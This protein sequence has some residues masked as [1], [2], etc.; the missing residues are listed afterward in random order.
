MTEGV[1]DRFGS[2]G[3]GG[4]AALYAG[5]VVAALV[6]VRLILGAGRHLHGPHPTGT[7]AATGTALA[8]NTSA[9]VWR[10]L[11][12][13]AVIIVTARVVGALFRRIDQPQVVGEI[14]AG[15]MLGPSLLGAAWPGA[16]HFLF[17]PTVLPFI[18]V[19]SQVGLLFFMFLIGLEL[20]IRLLKGRGHAAGLV[21]HVSIILPFLLGAAV[22]LLVFP[23]LGSH[24]GRFVPFALFMGAS[25]S[26][27]AFP[28]LARIL[29]E[30][31]IYKTRLGAVTLTCAAIDDVTA[32]CLLAVVVAV[33]RANGAGGVLRTIGLSIA[34]VTVMIGGVRPFMA[35]L[36]RHHEEQG[37][38]GGTV[39]ALLFVGI[40]LS[41]VATDRIG[42]HAI[43]GAFLFG[44]IMPQRS[45]F[46]RELVGKLEDFTVLFLLPLFFA[47]T[48]LR[49]RVGLIGTDPRL[50]GFCLLILLVAVAGKL[51][52]SA[53][54]AR[55]VGLEWR[56]SLAVGT[57]MNTRGLTELI[58]L[59]IGL[60]LG[61][62]PPTLFAMLVLMAL[63][64]TFMTTPA[65]SLVY[66]GGELTPSGEEVADDGARRWRVLVPILSPLAAT[67]LVHTA[68]RLVRDDDERPQIILLRVLPLPGSAYRTGPLAQEAM[69]ERAS[70]RLRPLVQLVE[71]AG[72]EAVPLVV[73]SGSVAATVV[74][75]AEER[76][77]DVVLMSWHRSPFG[78][79]LLGGTVGDV[80]RQA[81]ADVAVLIDPAHRGLA[82]PKGAGI[83]V[84]WGGGF[85]EDVGIDLALRLARSSRASV[86]LVGAGDADSAHELA[87]RAARAYQGTGVWTAALPVEGD[88]LPAV[89]ERARSADLVVLGVGDR[90]AREQRTLGSLR[91][92][93]T[94][95][96]PTP[97]LLVRRHGQPGA[98]R[99]G[100]WFRRHREWMDDTTGELDLR[101][102]AAVEAEAEAAIVAA[103]ERSRL[104]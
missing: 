58:I 78:R 4:S 42:I 23:Q 100:R 54:A 27:T 32:W 95:R 55:F 39:L 82:L 30:R 81:Q 29:T 45:E 71:G 25:M 80:L 17:G 67:E 49:T 43:F 70:E 101:E 83:V 22:S 104:P 68:I 74:R 34:F 9:V 64:T 21:S 99:P 77:P 33:A 59:N 35:R 86:T 15:I 28:V 102:V 76:Q 90:W 63:V 41:A 52:G 92:A 26:I 88:L 50:W 73:P 66:P 61:V 2:R 20:D 57:L 103:D 48:G 44:A 53:V 12:A 85:H 56:E 24:S 62:L 8:I 69:V 38:L 13:S 72:Y 87:E 16:T 10:L 11:V 65:L 60:D 51:G 98:R 3:R 94:A 91:E 6:V 46:I 31:G 1:T 97:L 19:L 5:L 47:F 79:R 84:P 14:V 40:L 89:F 36:A 37:E 96:A 75:A 93:I 7:A 18:D